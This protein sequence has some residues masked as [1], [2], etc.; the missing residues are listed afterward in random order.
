MVWLVELHVFVFVV[1]NLVHTYISFKLL[2]LITG[3]MVDPVVG[4]D[5]GDLIQGYD[6]IRIWDH[7]LITD[8]EHD[9]III[10]Y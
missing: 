7:G 1:G 9:V 5:L 6:S 8:R 10:H 3:E 2:V 4:K